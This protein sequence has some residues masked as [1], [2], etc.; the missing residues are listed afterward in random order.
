MDS[1]PTTSATQLAVCAGLITVSASSVLPSANHVAGWRRVIWV[2]SG[3]D[4]SLTRGPHLRG[5]R[6]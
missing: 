5:V 6:G 4:N 3:Q 1:G 2:T